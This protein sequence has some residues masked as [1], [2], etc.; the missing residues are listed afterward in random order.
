MSLKTFSIRDE[1]E[2]N[3]VT[4]SCYEVKYDPI[5]CAILGIIGD[6]IIFHYQLMVNDVIFDFQLQ[7]YVDAESFEPYS[8]E[9]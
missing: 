7:E 8:E 6:D 4:F 2:S 9:E 3:I 5:D 1:E